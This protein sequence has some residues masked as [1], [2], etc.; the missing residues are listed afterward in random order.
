MDA[1]EEVINLPE[2]MRRLDLVLVRD[3]GKAMIAEIV[4]Q[5]RIEF[6]VEDEEQ[7]ILTF[8]E[9]DYSDQDEER[10]F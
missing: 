5:S 10:I 8:N 6:N 7:D 3:K 4:L 1:G 9:A 2:L